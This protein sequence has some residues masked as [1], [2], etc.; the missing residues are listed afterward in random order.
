MHCSNCSQ[1]V[2]K[3]LSVRTHFCPQCQVVLNRDENAVINILNKELNE[4]GI[5]LSACGD[6]DV[7]QPVFAQ[8]CVSTRK[9]L[10]CL[11]SS[12]Y[13]LRFNGRELN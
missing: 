1:K 7:N 3:T 8:R 2:P 11:R 13:N 12:R 9:K 10:L 5:I 4:V 6:L